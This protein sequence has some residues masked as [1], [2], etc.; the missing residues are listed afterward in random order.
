MFILPTRESGGVFHLARSRFVFSNIT[1]KLCLKRSVYFRV[2]VTPKYRK[3]S[4]ANLN[5]N[6]DTG[7]D[8]AAGLI[9]KKTHPCAN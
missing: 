5:G 8:L 2:I 1:I 4:E 7:K 6:I 9:R 3:L